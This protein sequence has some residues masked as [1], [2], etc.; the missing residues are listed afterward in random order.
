M[1][2][3]DSP[4]EVLPPALPSPPRRAAW[5]CWPLIVFSLLPFDAFLPE[6]PAPVEA[7]RVERVDPSDLALLKI[8][9]RLVIVTH[10][11]EP[12][13]AGDSLD[14]LSETIRGD[15]PVSALALVESFLESDSERV[16]KT[17][18]RLTGTEPESVAMLTK[19]AV[20]RGL[21]DDER[22]MLRGELGWFADLARGPGLT[23][24]PGEEEIRVGSFLVLGVLGVI[25]TGVVLGIGVGAVLLILHLRRV[26]KD[27]ANNAFVPDVAPRGILLECFAL[28]LGIMTTGALAGAWFGNGIL[29]GAYGASVLI[30]LL[31]APMRGIRWADF[32]QWIG[33]HRGTGWRREIGCGCVGYLGVLAI[34]SIGISLTF[35]LTLIAGWFEG[36]GGPLDGSA[37]GGVPVGPEPHP[38]VGWMY[39]GTFWTRIACLALASGF[40]PLFEEIFF[41]GA[42]H[43]YFRGKFRFLPSAVLT[44]IIFAALHP[45]GFYAIPALASIGIGFSLLREWRDSLIAPMTAHA[46]NNGVLVGILWW[47]L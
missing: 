46:I 12:K 33:L 47:M 4:G 38:I 44:G 13:A 27:P 16:G 9:A 23:N 30:P 3:P 17:I 43:R 37:S 31:W 11:L 15:H 7:P 28:Y 19:A 8:Q 40:A 14:E 35:L 21:S 22:E 41:R 26:Q 1:S 24:P 45:Q 2:S 10:K 34:A 36:I 25:L 6:A 32:C 29:I 18:A 5:W 20:S 39:E 42:L